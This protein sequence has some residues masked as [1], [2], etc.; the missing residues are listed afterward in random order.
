M[1][2]YAVAKGKK[3]GIYTNWNDCKIQV[4][5]F[6]NAIYKKFKTRE[7]AET[8]INSKLSL[9]SNL[10]SKNKLVSKNVS[11][12]SS[13]NYVESQLQNYNFT[14]NYF[15]YTDGSC[16]NN[17]NKDAKAGIG[18]FF[19][20]NDIRNV[21]KPI[22]GKKTNNTAE[23]SA[24]LNTYKII[25]KDIIIGKNIAIVSDS[26]YAINCATNYGKKSSK[27]NYKNDKGQDIP[28]KELVKSIYELYKD[29]NN[30]R[31]IH[32]KAH[33]NNKDVHSIGN[34]NADKLANQSIV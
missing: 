30:I 18:I 34:D 14:P 4:N 20:I 16:Y 3:K 6:N 21:S 17:G 27:K 31:F 33:T 9:N 5:G 1:Y 22:Y 19:G 10:L 2:Y 12:I 7:E 24:I 13:E 25:E 32:C 29:I 8:F 23:L 28:N 26:K 11:N 15:V